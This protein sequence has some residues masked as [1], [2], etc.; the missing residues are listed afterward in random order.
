M[1][2]KRYGWPAAS[3][4]MTARYGPTDSAGSNATG[5]EKNR[6]RAAAASAACDAGRCS[7]TNSSSARSLS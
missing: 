2:R 1:S 3:W 7:A 5:S 6:L 4:S